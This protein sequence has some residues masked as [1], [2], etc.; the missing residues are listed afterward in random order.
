MF[1]NKH[2][3]LCMQYHSFTRIWVYIVFLFNPFKAS[4]S[5]SKENGIFP[6]LPPSTIVFLI[7]LSDFLVA[8]ECEHSFRSLIQLAIKFQAF[9]FSPFVRGQGGSGQWGGFPELEYKMDCHSSSIARPQ[10]AACEGESSTNA[11]RYIR[12]PPKPP[13]IRGC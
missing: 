3:I 5:L 6:L 8:Y 11:P 10:G 7:N 13:Q 4:F 2:L 1:T 9:V 12:P